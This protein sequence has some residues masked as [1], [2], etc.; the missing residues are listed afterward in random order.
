MLLLNSVIDF[1]APRAPLAIPRWT[2]VA[3]C[4]GAW[5]R[6]GA[7]AAFPRIR[8]SAELPSC[9]VQ[10]THERR[11]Q[12]SHRGQSRNS[13]GSIGSYHYYPTIYLLSARSSESHIGLL[14]Q[15]LIT[16]F[17]TTKI[18]RQP[19][20]TMSRAS[21]KR[22]RLP[23]KIHMCYVPSCPPP[24]QVCRLTSWP[25]NPRP[26]SGFICIVKTPR[27]RDCTLPVR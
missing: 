10:T 6:P 23:A 9:N 14:T 7:E 12:R 8:R 25:R 19:L 13:T 20:S 3:S 4:L 2:V 5:G 1:S 15:S 11:W 24:N 22:H 18:L 21:K 17:H 27:Q 26:V 16:T